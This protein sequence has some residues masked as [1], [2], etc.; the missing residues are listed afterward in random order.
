MQLYYI[1]VY[2]FVFDVAPAGPVFDARVEQDEPRSDCLLH[3]AAVYPPAGS[4]SPDLPVLHTVAPKLMAFSHD[5]RF[6]C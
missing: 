4:V 1:H 6:L 3:G 2:I 5:G